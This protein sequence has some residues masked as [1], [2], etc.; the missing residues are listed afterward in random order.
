VI[1]TSQ[2]PGIEENAGLLRRS[3]TPSIS[4]FGMSSSASSERLRL[5]QEIALLDRE[6]EQ[7]SAELMV[8]GRYGPRKPEHWVAG[9][10]APACVVGGVCWM[11]A[12]VPK[13]SPFLAMVC[14][15][16]LGIVFWRAGDEFRKA[17]QWNELE[18]EYQARRAV[19][20]VE[21][22]Q[23]QADPPA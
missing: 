8:H 19:L 13:L 16:G 17:S 14:L 9:L 7:R 2:K 22:A 1:R 18:S 20:E 5:E 3:T 4:E 12:A 15:S 21:L 6:W 11:I 23:T 10:M